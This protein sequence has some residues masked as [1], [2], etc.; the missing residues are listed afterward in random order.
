LEIVKH[1]LVRSAFDVLRHDGPAEVS[2][3]TVAEPIGRCASGS[4]G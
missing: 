2:Q 1:V 3:A 4:A